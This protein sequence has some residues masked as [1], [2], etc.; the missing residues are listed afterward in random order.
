M[1]ATEVPPLVLYIDDDHLNLRVFEANFRTRY[2][3]VC[4]RSGADALREITAR[5]SEIGVILTDQR[6]PEMTGVEL[7]ERAREV[8]PDALR[9][10]LTAYSDIQ[11]VMDAVNRG[12]VSR[13]F[14]KPWDKDEL[15]TALDDSLRIFTLQKRLRQIEDRMLKSERLATLGQVTAGVAHELMNP[16]SY[17]TQNVQALRRELE[18]LTG[19]A[20]RMLPKN[21]DAQVVGTLEELPGLVKDFHDGVDHIRNLAVRVRGQTKGDTEKE[22]ECELSEIATFA[23]KMARAEL[24]NRARLA[25]SGPTL[26]VK[27]GPSRL[28]QVLLNLVVNAAQAMESLERPGLIEV[29]W[30]RDALGRAQIDVRDNGCGIPPDVLPRVWEPLFTTKGENGTGLGLPI[31]REL[32]E[33]IGGTMQLQSEVG[34]GTVVTIVLPVG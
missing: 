2:R 12:Q 14:V 30:R 1:S 9:M 32:M 29:S 13:Y 27:S 16:V 6:M 10:I 17:L 5:P 8:V 11:A 20:S 7:L 3:V 19:Y 4:C 28:T 31:C 23:S 24:Q 22:T 26:H 18:V 33:Q 21:P 15:V 34:K 25:L